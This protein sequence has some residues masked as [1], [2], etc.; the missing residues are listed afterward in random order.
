MTTSASTF[1]ASDE[2]M[3]QSWAEF[4][5]QLK[6]NR[7]AASSLCPRWLRRTFTA[8]T[9]TAFFPVSGQSER[10]GAKLVFD[11][12]ELMPE[13]MGGMKEKI[14]GR[15]EK[16]CVNNCDH[17]VMPEQNRIAYFRNKYPQLSDLVLLENFPRKTDIPT[18]RKDLFRKKYPIQREQKIILHTG[19]IAAKRHVED[20]VES[21]AL[22]DEE[23]VL[24]LLGIA[25]NG[26]DEI[27]RSKIKKLALE[28]RVFLHDPVPQTQILQYMA[29]CDIGTAFYQNTN[30]NNVYCASNKLYEYIA[31]DKVVL[32]NNY[33][34]LIESVQRWRQGICLAEVS[35]KSLASAYLHAADPTV[36]APGA[37]KSFWDDQEEYLVQMYQDCSPVLS[38]N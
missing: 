12:H 3:G 2:A 32:T 19:L 37:K 16:Q 25:F 8:T 15:I 17:I 23:F 4:L 38:S 20:L 14:W 30:I 33:P 29:C 35:P 5:E 28:R 18:R 36:V 21:M 34:G 9:S 6:F 10:T 7:A 26:Y 27:L 11:A 22:C 31:L 24:V 1:I 13:S